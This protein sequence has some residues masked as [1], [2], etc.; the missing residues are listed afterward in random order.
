MEAEDSV[1]SAELDQLFFSPSLL[2]QF[3]EIEDCKIAENSLSAVITYKSRAEAE[4]VQLTLTHT[5][6]LFTTKS[7]Q[8]TAYFL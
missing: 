8:F 6:S 3:G 1:C 4:Q 5:C 2:K 7:T